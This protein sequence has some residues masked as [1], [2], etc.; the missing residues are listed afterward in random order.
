MHARNEILPCSKQIVRELSR[1]LKGHKQLLK[2]R[3]RSD[4]TRAVCE[5]GVS[6]PVVCAGNYVIGLAARAARQKMRTE[7]GNYRSR[8][9]HHPLQ[10]PAISIGSMTKRVARASQPVSAPLLLIVAHATRLFNL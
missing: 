5:F 10:H 4:K 2:E 1:N 8:I 7:S 3:P 6:G 9:L